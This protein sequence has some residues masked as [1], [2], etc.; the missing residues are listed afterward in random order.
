[1]CFNSKQILLLITFFCVSS[2]SFA[3]MGGG[4]MGGNMGMGMGMGGGPNVPINN[5]IIFLLI[6]GLLFGIKKVYSLSKQKVDS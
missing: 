5:G 4:P 6:A 2:Y 3:G 1:M